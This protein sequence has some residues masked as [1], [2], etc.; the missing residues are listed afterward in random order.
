MNSTS[1]TAMSSFATPGSLVFWMIA[2]VSVKYVLQLALLGLAAICRTYFAYGSITHPE[3]KPL[4]EYSRKNVWLSSAVD[5]DTPEG[6]MIGKWFVGLVNRDGRGLRIIWI[7]TP[8]GVSIPATANVEK[9]VGTK[10]KVWE[11]WLCNG[12]C[13][14]VQRTLTFPDTPTG[15]Q[16][17]AIEMIISAAAFSERNGA[18]FNVTALLYG[19]VG[20][21]KS[22][23]AYF[24]AQRLKG[25]V[26]ATYNPVDPAD[27]LSYLHMKASPTRN[28]PLIVVIDE[29]DT[30]VTMAFKTPGKWRPKS[31]KF[32]PDIW[33][34]QS[35]NS[36]TDSLNMYENTIF[37]LT[38]NATPRISTRLT[39]P[40]SGKVALTFGWASTRAPSGPRQE[41][42]DAFGPRVKPC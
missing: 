5:G 25:A 23:I 17:A 3:M 1:A 28:K 41:C 39:V 34:K 11:R 20:C 26:C 7:I 9:A 31:G 18:G 6:F 13:Q 8:R 14:Y 33:N 35:H 27:S 15:A 37:L 10:T 21:G 12:Q 38:M 36:F 2:A 19:P 4:L 16:T 42:G 29:W 30:I 24:L 22:Q 40:L 32:I